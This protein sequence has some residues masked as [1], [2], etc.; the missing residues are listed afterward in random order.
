MR[1]FSFLTV[2]FLIILLV[3]CSKE[4]LEISD[5][6]T[7]NSIENRSVSSEIQVSVVASSLVSNILTVDFAIP[8]NVNVLDVEDTQNIAFSSE[9]IPL[10]VISWEVSNGL[11]S[12]YF[13][14]G[15]NNLNGL[16]IENSQFIIIVDGDIE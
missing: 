8:P 1:K 7:E 16:H 9:V 4:A 11:L 12:L 6:P 13:D 14:E 5:F 15:A 3:S 10:S 2:C